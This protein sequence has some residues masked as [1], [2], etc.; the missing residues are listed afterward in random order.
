MTDLFVK[1]C[2]EKNIG[3]SIDP[4]LE[5]FIHPNLCIDKIE[6]CPNP[7][8]QYRDY[9]KLMVESMCNAGRG[10]VLSPTRSR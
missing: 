1:R 3:Y 6:E 10:V 7:L 4:E 9:Q 2:K 8:F 5:L